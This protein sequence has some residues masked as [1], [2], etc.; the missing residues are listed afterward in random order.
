MPNIKIIFEKDKVYVVTCEKETVLAEITLD[1]LAELIQFRYATPWNN[2]KDVIEKIT[3]VL[4][5]IK[6][7]YTNTEN[8]QALSKQR[9]F[10][11]IKNRK[12]FKKS[13]Q[14]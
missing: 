13:S 14:S 6:E 11:R 12:Y 10:E 9:V 8:P 4:E 1:E 2:S 7:A 3:Y 5:D